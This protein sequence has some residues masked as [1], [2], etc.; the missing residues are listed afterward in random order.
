MA[1]SHLSDTRLDVGRRDNNAI[2]SKRLLKQG[3]VLLDHRDKF[4]GAFMM[5][6]RWIREGKL[7]LK[8]DILEGIEQTPEAFFRVMDGVSNGK[9]LVKLA[10][11]DHQV[12][13]INRA[14]GRMLTA[15]W[16]PTRTIARRIT[17]GL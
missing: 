12:D 13:P 11:I 6:A 14:L 9:Q 8:E 3:F 16:F 5:L 1:I 15:S 4:R 10:D 17:G 7:K 2:L